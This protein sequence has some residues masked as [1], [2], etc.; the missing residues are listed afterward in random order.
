MHKISLATTEDT[1]ELSKLL[2]LLMAQ[3]ADFKP[4]VEAQERG[5]KMIINSP[6]LGI[7]LKLELEGKV[8][9]M[10]SILFTVSTAIGEKV[11]IFEDFVGFPELRNLGYGKK[12]FGAAIELAEEYA[13][14]RITLLTDRDNMSA[15]RFYKK[16]G[17]KVSAMSP[18]RKI[19]I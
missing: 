4:D 18:F 7:V 19:L 14:K 5:L 3:E 12:L 8:I 1:Q 15:R 17:M 9:G 16:Q 6:E 13:C 11:A 10:I 2:S